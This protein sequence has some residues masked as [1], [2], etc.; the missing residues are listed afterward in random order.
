MEMENRSVARRLEAE[1]DNEVFVEEGEVVEGTQPTVLD[2][3]SVSH[4]LSKTESGE[5]DCP[6]CYDS[7]SKT[8]RVTISC[9]HD[10]CF[11]CTKLLLETCNEQQKNVACPMCRYSCFLL[12]TPDEAQYAELS[13][14]VQ[15]LQEREVG[16]IDD[17]EVYAFLYN[18]FANQFAD[19]IG[20][21]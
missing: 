2:V 18:Q 14:V 10:F 12:E 5:F 13:V 21:F 6:I 4:I 3:I 7:F 8:K 17:R 11:G 9:N 19:E 1:F 16:I 15:D 20:Q